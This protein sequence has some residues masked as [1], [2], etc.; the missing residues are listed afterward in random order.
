[1][2]V[3]GR[4]GLAVRDRPFTGRSSPTVTEVPADT[5]IGPVDAALVR[6]LLR[7]SAIPTARQRAIVLALAFATLTVDR[8]VDPRTTMV[9]GFPLTVALAAWLWSRTTA[10]LLAGLLTMASAMMTLWWGASTASAATVWFGAG[11][12]AFSL[13]LTAMLMG[14]LRSYVGAAAAEASRDP[15]T[16]LLS[17]RAVMQELRRAL[18]AVDMYPVGV[19]FF[20]LDGLK[21]V[22]DL[23]GH[24]GGDD[25]LR[26]F[27][28]H[29]LDSVR[30]GDVVGRLGGDEFLLVCP[31]TSA[32]AASL[33][34]G[35]IAAAPGAPT[36]S[37]GAADNRATWD[38]DALVALADAAMYRAKSS[39][40]R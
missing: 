40:P 35:R 2:F 20:D 13:A 33:L 39:R 27:A 32:E 7:L 30:D 24:A 26:R 8:L 31:N 19:V 23:V 29:L 9:L 11:T 16:G 25:H 36:V 5:R 18:L 1:V 4:R 3:V 15:L 38:A 28:R 22:N 6:G 14:A 12:R 34:A 21:R 37:W 10:L 17:R